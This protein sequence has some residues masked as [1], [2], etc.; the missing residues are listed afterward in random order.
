IQNN[1]S[2]NKSVDVYQLV[3]LISGTEYESVIKEITQ[4]IQKLLSEK[5]NMLY[6]LTPNSE[7]IKQINYQIENQKRLLIES[8][9]AVRM[10]YKTRY[11][12]LLE[13]SSDFKS[14]FNQKPEDEVEFSRL[15]RVHSI[16]EKYYT[17]LLEK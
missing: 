11:K 2:K 17:M 12:N 4:N 5:E 14:K 6:A 16:S 15:N 13:R 1:I 10:K 9:D 7:S 3:S 8:L